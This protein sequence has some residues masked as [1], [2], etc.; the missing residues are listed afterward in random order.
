MNGRAHPLEEL[1]HPVRLKI[2]RDHTIV[3]WEG[4]PDFYGLPADAIRGRDITDFLPCLFGL[5]EDRDTRFLYVNLTD[6]LTADL[7]IYWNSDGYEVLILDSSERKS[8][9]QETQQIANELG[10]MY[11][12]L[13]KLSHELKAKNVALDE[14]NQA[15]SLFISGIS[16]EFRTP[17]ISILGHLSWLGKDIPQDS[18]QCRSLKSID[19]SAHYLLSLIDNLLNQGKIESN[20]TETSL[21]PVKMGTFFDQLIDSIAPLT[22]EKMLDLVAELNQ[23][24]HLTLLIDE[25]HLHQVLLNLLSNAVKYTRE[26]KVSISTNYDNGTLTVSVTDTGIGIPNNARANLLK[27]FSRASNSHEFQGAGLGLSIVQGL[28]TAMQGTLDIESEVGKGSCVSIHVPAKTAEQPS[29]PAIPPATT[30]NRPKPTGP[31]FIIDDNPDILAVYELFFGDAGLQTEMFTTPA[32]FMAATLEHLPPLV[33]M[34]YNLGS[35]NGVDVILALRSAGY[36]GRIILL[37]ATAA[38]DQKL[39]QQAMKAGCTK[40]IPKPMEVHELINLTES[41]LGE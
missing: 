27:P 13:E 39:Y 15:K 21:K 11:G 20:T 1:L 32:E 9:Q 8:S 12:K 40:F 31:V 23:V 17:M 22:Q 34:D 30:E 4:D 29:A 36:E 19:R 25:Y 5:E 41:E 38:I 7:H 24:R 26:G 10:L 37:T 33:L 6:T 14:A 2:R 35:E 28:L 18:E 3:G 16:H